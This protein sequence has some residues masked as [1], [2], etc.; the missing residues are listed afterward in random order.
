MKHKLSEK[1]EIDWAKMT[2]LQ[3]AANDYTE[4]KLKK[5]LVFNPKNITARAKGIHEVYDEDL[6]S[7]RY[8]YLTYDELVELDALQN[9][10]TKQPIS[11]LEKSVHILWMQLKTANPTLTVA[12]MKTWPFEVITKLLSKLQGEGS[13]FFRKPQATPT[14]QA[15]KTGST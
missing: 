13:F 15:S 1:T 6:G 14:L 11:N 4:A 12:E 2:E 8:T 7:I 3:N 10:Q 5:A 9:P